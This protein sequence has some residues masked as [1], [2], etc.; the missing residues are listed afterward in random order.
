MSIEVKRKP[1]LIS[2]S[3][4]VITRYFILTDEPEVNA[5]QV[6]RIM[7]FSEK[8]VDTLVNNTLK[9]YAHRHRDLKSLLL[10]NY[11]LVRGQFPLDLGQKELTPQRKLLIGIYFTMEYSIESAAF[12]NPSIVEAPDQSGTKKGEKKVILS[13]RAIGEGHVSSIVFRSGLLTAA[14]DILLDPPHRKFVEIPERIKKH[15]YL[16][17]EFLQQL[18]EIELPGWATKLVTEKCPIEFTY[19][20]LRKCI[21]ETL[22]TGNFSEQER[23]LIDTILWVAR[24]YYEITFSEETTISERVIFP[25][26]FTESRGLE[27]TRW[28]RFTDDDGQVTYYAT[29]T[30]FNG[31]AIMPRLIETKDFRHFKIVPLHGN[32]VKNKGMAIFP[33][34]IKGKYYTLSRMD[35][36]NNFVISSNEI[37]LWNDAVKIQE[38]KY[39]WELIKLGNN[40]SPIETD[41]GWLV[42]THGVGPM[43]RYHLSAILLDLEDP[44]KVIGRLKEPLLW[45]NEKEREG[46]VPNVVYS[47]GS[48]I[49]NGELILPYGIADEASTFATISLKEL[50]AELINSK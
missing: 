10:K 17:E 22:N 13:F 36:I 40:G 16:R 28:V 3:D 7:S 11:Q 37:H 47:C 8:E 39:P 12:V 45:A 1:I 29:Y 48:I 18:K 38:P 33:R 34:K 15:T 35:Q 32:S 19:G 2:S 14:N 26:V 25:M 44:T 43:R 21:E 30:A 49:H 9:E 50:L 41:E 23:S 20:S 24:S 27:D 4:R 42:I 6:K 31:V 5:A 46:Y